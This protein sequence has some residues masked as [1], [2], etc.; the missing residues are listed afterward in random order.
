MTSIGSVSK[1]SIRDGSFSYGQKSNKKEIFKDLNLEVAEGEVLCLLG[2]NGCGKTTLL[3]CLNGKLKL[4]GGEALLGDSNIAS[5][6]PDAVARKVGTVFQAHTVTFPFSVLEMVRM[7]RAPHLGFF[8]SPS[9]KDTDIALE[10]LE[11]VG[12]SHLKDKPYTQTSGGESQLVFIART[13]A[14]E[15]E[16]ILLDEPT[17]HLDF[18]NQSLVLGMVDKL[19]HEKKLTIV[20][21]TH[22]PEH[23][24]LHSSRV[25]LMNKGKFLAIGTPD[26]VMTEETLGKVYGMEVRIISVDDRVSGKRLKFVIPTTSISQT[27]LK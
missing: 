23:A 18:K 27:A 25:A 7:G 12:M 13:L 2:P 1:I 10:A 11:A 26:D 19:A 17:S 22:L 9:K 4:N 21:T 6:A 14:Q 15:P 24:L 20:M 8:S 16:V 5:M 3:N